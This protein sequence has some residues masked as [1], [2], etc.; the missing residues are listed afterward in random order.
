MG[1]DTRLFSYT[2]KVSDIEYVAADD[3]YTL[4]LM[5]SPRGSCIQIQSFV[6][7]I[8]FKLKMLIC[9]AVIET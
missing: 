3:Q 4:F 7:L 6:A 8:V 5:K 1:Q 2:L 9:V